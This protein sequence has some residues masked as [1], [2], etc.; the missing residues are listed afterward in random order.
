MKI[1]FMDMMKLMNNVL[2]PAESRPQPL[3]EG[4]N[5]QASMV[6]TSS[7]PEGGA[8]GSAEIHQRQETDKCYRSPP[9]FPPRQRPRA[10]VNDSPGIDSSLSQQPEYNPAGRSDRNARSWR[11]GDRGKA[12]F[13]EE[14]RLY[15]K[16]GAGNGN[17][18]I[19]VDRW[20]LSFGSKDDGHSVEFMQRQHQCPWSEVLWNFYV[21]LTGRAMDTWAQLR[22]AL[23][24]R[25]RGHQTDH[26]RKTGIGRLGSPKAGGTRPGWNTA[27]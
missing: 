8:N 15:A 19:R 25:F 21:L 20:N 11:I 24:D 4:T 16:A 13:R 10:P 27:K 6:P 23:F 22:R 18:Y 12:N 5:R 26:E 1:G 17:R 14:P 7:C 2:R 3:Q 9:E